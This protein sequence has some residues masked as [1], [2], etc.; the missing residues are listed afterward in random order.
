VLAG[1]AAEGTTRIDNVIVI[2]RGYQGLDG[3]LRALG[4]EVHRVAEEDHNAPVAGSQ[5]PIE[6]GTVPFRRA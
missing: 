1:L 6:W 5:E 4:A 3:R 2:D